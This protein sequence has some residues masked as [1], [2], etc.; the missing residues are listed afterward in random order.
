MG[1]KSSQKQAAGLLRKVLALLTVLIVL[2]VL[3]LLFQFTDVA[4]RVWDRL[5]NTSSGFLLLY[6]AG[7]AVI[8]AVGAGLVYRV[9]RIGRRKRGSTKGAT[10]AKPAR[11]SLEA[12]RRKFDAAVAQ[13][14]DVGDVA[15]DLAQAASEVVP[16]Q[17]TV[18]LF[19]KI[20]TGK[21]SLI[22]TILP[23]AR[24]EVDIIGGSTTRVE[25]YHYET[26]SGLALTLYDMPGTHQ[27]ESLPSMDA[28]V[29]KA[30]RRA[31]VVVY[32]IDQDLTASDQQAIAALYGFEKPLMVALNKIGRYDADEL[33]ALRTNIERRLPSDVA[34]V[35]TDSAYV[36]TVPLHKA[37][38]ELAYVERVCGGEIADL[39]AA[40]DQLGAQ[41]AQLVSQQR[42]ALLRLADESLTQRVQSYRRQRGEAMV[43]AYSRKAMLGGVAAVGP[44]TDILIQGYLG[45]DVEVARWSP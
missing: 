41:S 2:A 19:G 7:V 42:Q 21:S 29:L 25:R 38:G 10:V 14:I 30:T 39:L 17:L 24:I 40:F 8:A 33:E 31:H 15:D 32:V 26:S 18:A 9:W 27:A 20:S 35:L 28:D 11:L 3:L 23:D 12:L 6:G 4:F 45:V 5:Q 43:K 13:G 44:G 36:T 1:E 22:Q 16:R 37:S 34:L